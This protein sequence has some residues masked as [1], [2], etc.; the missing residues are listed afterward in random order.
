MGNWRTVNIEGTVSKEEARGMIEFLRD[1][2]D[3]DW[4]S[5]WE[6]SAAPFVMN[7]SMCGLNQ[8]VKEDGTINA[9][10]NLSERDFDNDDIEYALQ[11][12]ASMFPSLSITLHSGSDYE[13]LQCSAT[14]HVHE[15]KV[16]RCE[17]EV[18]VIKEIPSSQIQMN[19]YLTMLN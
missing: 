10:G 17:P 15:G 18:D 8:W 14:F 4:G 1:D 16:E 19:L 7:R 13:S 2:D 12:L 11:Y 3:K 9:I 5:P 6:T